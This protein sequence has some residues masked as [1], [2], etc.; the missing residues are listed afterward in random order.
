[1]SCIYG[2]F[3]AGPNAVNYARSLAGSCLEWALRGGAE[4]AGRN[5]RRAHE[6]RR[7]G[8]SIQA[9]AR[10]WRSDDQG[11]TVIRYNKNLKQ[12][13]AKLVELLERFRI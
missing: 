2:G 1:M 8:E 13:D 6:D 5:Q 3:V 7:D 10:T 4:A 9:V 11:L 12:T